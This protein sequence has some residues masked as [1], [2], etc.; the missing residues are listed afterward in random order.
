MM[1]KL[2]LVFPI[3]LS[4]AWGQ[5]ERPGSTDAQFLK[6]DV[7]A[8]SAGMGS[9][10]ISVPMGAEAAYYNPAALARIEKASVVFNHTRWFAGISHN[11]ASAAYTFGRMGTFA[12]SMTAL[13]TD[14][15][16]VTTPLQPD[17]TGETFY[18]G[19]YRFGISYARILTDHVTF[20][21]SV[22]Y[23]NMSLYQGFSASAYSG[24]IAVLYVT[25]FRNFRF[26]MKISN[27]GSDIKFVNEPYPLPTNFTF[28]LSMNAIERNNQKLLMSFSAVKPNDGQPLGQSGLEWSYRNT[29]FIRTGYRLNHGVA[30]YSFGGGLAM[31]IGSYNLSA[32][33]AYSDFGLLGPA[34]RFGVDLNF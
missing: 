26:G 19:N 21:G 29:L 34:P 9:A 13:Y 24:D 11:F 4:L 12:A 3:L 28:G 30:S 1:S 31:H 10:F 27:F 18:S 20:G 33:Y 8:R 16:K 5:Y 7:T 2:V 32:N 17:G 25:Y 22:N 14:E 23:I 15:M 6:I